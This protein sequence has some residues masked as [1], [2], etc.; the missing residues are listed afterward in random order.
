MFYLTLWRCLVNVMKSASVNNFRIIS[1]AS[2]SSQ[3]IN[4]QIHWKQGVHWTPSEFFYQVHICSVRS[5][6][7][8]VCVTL[9]ILFLIYIFFLIFFSCLT[10]SHSTKI[11]MSLCITFSEFRKILCYYHSY[12]IRIYIFSLYLNCQLNWHQK[13]SADI[14]QIFLSNSKAKKRGLWIWFH[15]IS[16]IY[17]CVFKNTHLIFK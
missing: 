13:F 3:E 17:K 5:L 9:C 4:M 16:S 8:I 6:V 1:H 11:V 14:R 7:Y 15:N 10:I 2:C 12:E